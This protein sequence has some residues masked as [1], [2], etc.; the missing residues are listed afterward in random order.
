MT[1]EV[2]S[3]VLHKINLGYQRLLNFEVKSGGFSWFGS[4]PANLVLT[5]YGLLLFSDM[6]KV[7]PIDE[8][9][10]SRTQ[11]F[12][13]DK[14]NEDG[15]WSERRIPYSWKMLRN[16][17]IPTTAFI[18]WALVESGLKSKKLDKS[19]KF[20]KYYLR[21]L[22]QTYLIAL[23]ANI[24]ATAQPKAKKTIEVFKNLINKRA[25][26][27]ECC[28]WRPKMQTVTYS[29]GRTGAIETTALIA[30]GLLKTK[31]DTNTAL[32]AVRYIVKQKDPRGS[33]YS[34][35]ATVLVLRTLVEAVKQPGKECSGEIE[36]SVNGRVAKSI[37]ITK[38]N[39]DVTHL[40]PLKKY[41]KRG[42]NKILIKKKGKVFVTYQVV[43]R[44]YL[45]WRKLPWKAS[46][47][48]LEIK[49]KYNK[50]KLNVYDRIVSE[51]KVKYNGKTPTYMI[52]VDLGIPPGF[53]ISP[54]EFERLKKKKVINNYTFTGRQIT[55]YFGNM[56]EG[57]EVSF[58]YSLIAKF[59]VR[60]AVPST[61]AYE[62]YNPKSHAESKE[63]KGA[64]KYIEVRRR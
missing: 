28:F 24:L 17:K 47:K 5:A 21:E 4:P 33:W 62:F 12:L 54:S 19:I 46:K 59:P 41:T 30:Y 44:Y 13:L 61:R 48:P 8:R 2:E 50:Y 38:K 29:T 23:I 35:Q 31:I 15:S 10:I 9:I 18:T 51:V 25:E 34:T 53:S 32:K 55:L 36:I 27:K 60:A 49:V 3:K 26:G 14:Q 64:Q 6:N 52:I 56:S 43:G 16:K 7:Y 57:D 45:P 20:L 42:K 58:K 22:N 11:K 40:I 39:F 63:A 1:P 37:E